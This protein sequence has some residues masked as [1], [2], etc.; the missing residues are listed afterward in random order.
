MDALTVFIGSKLYIGILIA[1]IL[2]FVL[3]SREKKIVLAYRALVALPTAYLLG[4]LANSLIASPRPF[5]VENIQPL[6]AHIPNNGFPSEHTL[7]VATI[8]A[9][10]YTEQ[11]KL[12]LIL[13]VLALSVGIARVHANVHHGIDVVGGIAVALASVYIACHFVKWLQKSCKDRLPL[14]RETN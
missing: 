6:I 11:K 8:S 1:G 5:V 12:G 3:L 10:V 14:L 7:L 2:F 4:R 13:G 9:L